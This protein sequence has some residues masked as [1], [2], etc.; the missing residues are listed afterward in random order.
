MS[1]ITSFHTRDGSGIES[2][3]LKHCD[4]ILKLPLHLSTHI[5][6]GRVKILETY[7]KS[8]E[9]INCYPHVFVYLQTFS[10]TLSR[11]A[12]FWLRHVITLISLVN[13]YK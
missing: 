6:Q 3:L 11:T 12:M 10:D 5:M 8:E 13:S 9:V 7:P 2:I 4:E 1:D